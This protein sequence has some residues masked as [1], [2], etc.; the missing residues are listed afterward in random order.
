MAGHAAHARPL[1]DIAG[2]EHAAGHIQAVLY[3]MLALDH[4]PLLPQQQLCL[5]IPGPCKLR[6]KGSDKFSSIV[7]LQDVDGGH[8]HH[9]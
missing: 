5:A 1:G 4:P 6:K 3:A 8:W 7:A 9:Y 2:G